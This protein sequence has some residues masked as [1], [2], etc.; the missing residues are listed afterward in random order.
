MSDVVSPASATADSQPRGRSL[1][2]VHLHCHSE[3][4]L[5]DGANRITDLVHKAKEYE[6]PALALTDHGCLFGAWTFRKAAEKE[7]IRPIL[8]MEAY[9]APGERGH[10]QP[11]RVAGREMKK[12]YYHLVLL[13]RDREGY[14]NLVKL[15]SI[16]YLEGFYYKPRI[17]RE[18]IERHAGG[19]ICTSACMAGEV[20]RRLAEDN[21]E[22]ARE[23]AEW[24][25]NVFGDRY[26]LEV[27]GHDTPG[28]DDLNRKIFQLSRDI[29]VPVVATNDAH[30]LRREDHKA[31]DILLCIGLGKDHDDKNRMRYDEELYFKSGPEMAERF[32]T[33]PRCSRTRWPSPIRSTSLSKRSISCPNFLCRRTTGTATDTSAIWLWRERSN[34]T[35]IRFRPRARAAGL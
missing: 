5:L 20:A 3:Y 2:F 11:M 23:A 8:G 17:D 29:D 1:S 21:R 16:G 31:H 12:P 34:A 19:L 27:Q 33:I 24:Y 15:S 28:Q 6:M 30:F 18:V 14:R 9:V 35:A 4:S 32:P 13:A 22:A 25:A 26:Y 7:G 10:K